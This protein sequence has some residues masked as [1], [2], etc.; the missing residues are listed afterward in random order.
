MIICWCALKAHQHILFTLFA[1]AAYHYLYIMHGIPFGKQY[2]RHIRL[3]QAKRIAA[4]LAFEM[5]VVIVMMML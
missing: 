1:N 3:L 5:Y 4:L 2:S